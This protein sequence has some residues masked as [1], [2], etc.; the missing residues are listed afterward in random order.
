MSNDNRNNNNNNTK[1]PVFSLQNINHSFIQHAY[2]F[3]QM[4]N[5]LVDCSAITQPEYDPKDFILRYKEGDFVE[6]NIGKPTYHKAKILKCWDRGNAYR[7]ELQNA[8]KDNVWAP[9]DNDSYVRLP[10]LEEVPI[11]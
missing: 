11:M 9:I 8:N 5:E 7:L 10:N 4:D 6:A 3:G 2:G 1:E